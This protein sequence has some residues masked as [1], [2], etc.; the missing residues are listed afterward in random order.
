M[1]SRLSPRKLLMLHPVRDQLVHTQ[2][3]LLVLL[4]IRKIPLEPLNMGVALE[5]QHVGG[6]AVEEEAIMADDDGAAR[7]IRQR[8]FQGP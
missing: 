5:G 3:P 1:R 8:V 7:I 4:V 2:T 6:D